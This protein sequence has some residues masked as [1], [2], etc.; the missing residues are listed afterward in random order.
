MA[1]LVLLQIA[2]SALQ[3]VAD[4][5]HKDGLAELAVVVEAAI[6]KLQEVHGSEVTKAQLESLRG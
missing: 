5:A 4:A 3:A 2:L 1:W 6:A